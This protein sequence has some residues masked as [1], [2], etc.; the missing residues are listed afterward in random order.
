M[1]LNKNLLSGT[2]LSDVL[3]RLGLLTYVHPVNKR[4]RMSWLF[5]LHGLPRFLHLCTVKWSLSVHSGNLW[6]FFKR[7]C[8]CQI[9]RSPLRIHVF[10][11][12]DGAGIINCQFAEELLKC[13]VPKRGYRIWDGTLSELSSSICKIYSRSYLRSF[14]S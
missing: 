12:A 5:V 13:K 4:I 11:P 9:V 3:L 14:V 1:L 6:T 8:N 2:L 7:I 10:F